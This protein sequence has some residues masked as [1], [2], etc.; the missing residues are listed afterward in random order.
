MSLFQGLSHFCSHQA[1]LGSLLKNCGLQ[2]PSAPEILIQQVWNGVHESAFSTS[3]SGG[4]ETNDM[5]DRFEKCQLNEQE[6]LHCEC[7]NIPLII[8]P[9]YLFSSYSE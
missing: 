8:V 2:G 6:L 5:Q 3:I 7:V 1:H 4:F 9:V